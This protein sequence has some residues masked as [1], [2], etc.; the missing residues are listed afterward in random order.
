MRQHA[1]PARARAIGAM[2][3]LALYAL[4]LRADTFVPCTTASVHGAALP[5]E[6]EFIAS[7]RF[8]EGVAKRS[9]HELPQ[10][11]GG[12]SPVDGSVIHIGN[13]RIFDQI[14]G[15]LGNLPPDV[16][17]EDRRNQSYI[18]AATPDGGIVAAGYGED[19]T[20]RAYLGLGYALADLQRRL[21]QRD[22]V[23]GFAVPDSPVVASPAMPNRT[24][25]LMN[26][27]H[28]N[29]GLSLEYFSEP[30]LEDYVDFLVAARYSRV[31]FWQWTAN[32]LYPGNFDQNRARNEMTHRAM[33]H[34]F[35]YA[36]RRGL[37]VYHQV[38]PMHANVDLLPDDPKFVATGYYGR[39]SICWA[40]PEGR[41]L[42]RNMLRQEMAYYG[43]VDGYIVWFYDPGGC[44]C[45]VCLPNQAQH[46]HEQFSL[47]RELASTVS[48]NAR[49]QAVLW[50]TWC[51][52]EY[53]TRGIPYE[54]ADQVR[55]FVQDFLGRLRKDFGPREL[56]IMDTGELDSSNIYNGRVNPEEFQRS[57]FVY[58]IMGL[59]SES[60]YPFAA[61]K[62]NEMA[63]MLT[64]ARDQ[65]LEDANF[66][67]QYANVNRPSVFAFGDILFDPAGTP[68]TAI[69]RFVA[70]ATTGSSR[71]PL[72]T[73]LE[74]LESMQAAP[75]Y[76]AKA[77]A[78]SEAEAAW[79][80]LRGIHDSGIDPEWLSGFL[81]A[82]RYYLAMARAGSE[83]TF[84]A[85]LGALKAELAAI[86]M[87]RHFAE[88]ALGKDLAASH[89]RLYWRGPLNDPSIVGLPQ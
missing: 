1:I 69:Q 87:W 66:F 27:D 36:R 37:E 51:F 76:A 83:E 30:D 55:A 5:S 59:P 20:P 41:E 63:T 24:L 44:F 88:H 33:R 9:G 31:S 50:P 53:T 22:G 38:T 29:P 6:A 3:L 61:F 23:W 52:H 49:F 54:S 62:I 7:Q 82:Q 19:D 35:G 85:S 39:N 34:L 84:Q 68:D 15:A 43:P 57:A 14:P 75:D 80:A 17:D 64:K 26:S 56:T 79:H 10:S 46:L 11:W 81:I 16:T 13:A 58:S 60:M 72:S 86:P 28:M 40:Q 73:V 78:L 4:P 71:G 65:G 21:E 70:T 45:D 42:A 67:L 74:R 12:A 89:V 48:P 18:L 47:V 25:Y 77:A 2:A 32:M 8:V